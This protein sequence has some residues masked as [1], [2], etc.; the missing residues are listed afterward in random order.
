LRLNTA[1]PAAVVVALIATIAATPADLRG[2]TL[3]TPHMGQP[4]VAVFYLIGNAYFIH[5]YLTSGLWALRYTRIA[6]RHLAFGLRAISLGL[7]GLALASVNR[8]VWVF[9]R[10]KQPGSHGAFNTFNW[11]LNDWSMGVVLA[12]IGYCAGTHIVSHLRSVVKHHRMYRELAPLWE[13][14]AAAYP[15]LI[16]DREPA[17]SRW[18]RFWPRRI[19]ERCHRRLIECRDGLV[20]LSPQLARVAPEADLASGPAEQIARHIAEAL[21]LE[22]TAEHSESAALAARI[23]VPAADD[24]GA[25]AREL[26]AISRAYADYRGKPSS[27]PPSVCCAGPQVG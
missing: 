14:L 8:I 2:H 18:Q 6:N 17:G 10:I 22:S 15:N 16:L 26:I 13:A 23:A 27:S 4:A 20:W 21:A 12:G 5:A 25:D 11:A 24:V 19:H 1:L 9:L 3:S 7:L